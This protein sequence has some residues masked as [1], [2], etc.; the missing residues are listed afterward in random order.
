MNGESVGVDK[1]VSVEELEELARKLGWDYARYGL[2]PPVDVHAGVWEEFRA[3]C[4]K[5]E[6]TPLKHDRYVRKWLQ[7]RASA[8]KRER[9]VD[10]GVTVELLRAID[11]PTCPITLVELT[12]GKDRDS[13]WSIDRLDNDGAYV[14]RNL[15]VMSRK[16]N[17]AKGSKS[18]WEVYELSE[19][20]ETVK[21]LSPREWLRLACIM[22]AV[23]MPHDKSLEHIFLPLAAEFHPEIPRHSW[24]S[25]QKLLL[26]AC[27]IASKRNELIRG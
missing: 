7:I 23:C 4:V 20:T 6:A 21:G 25:L 24:Y 22:H 2:R 1:L 11:T 14:P 19:G 26:G 17:E 27:S 10:P 12:H 5:Y 13:D 8:L 18:F 3:G 9:I 15:A 16:A